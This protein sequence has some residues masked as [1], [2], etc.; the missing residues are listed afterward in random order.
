[1]LAGM[2]MEQRAAQPSTRY[3]VCV[4][5]ILDE[6]WLRALQLHA[7]ATH[8]YYTETPRTVLTLELADQ[9]ALLGLLLRLHNLG[10]TVLSV[11]L[12]AEQERR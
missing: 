2:P 4:Q 8:R 9:A 11:E 1:M 6:G 12:S 3:S 5:R 7:V 10:L